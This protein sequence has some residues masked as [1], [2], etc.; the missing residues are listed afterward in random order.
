VDFNQQAL[1]RNI[2]AVRPGMQ[3]LKLSAKT[4]E[5]MQEFLDHLHKYRRLRP[6]T[7][8]AAATSHN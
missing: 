4:G 3:I 7:A 8:S 5:G 2:E 1:D 6:Q